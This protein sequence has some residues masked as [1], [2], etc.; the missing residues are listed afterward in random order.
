MSPAYAFV[1]ATGIGFVAVLR[2]L[3]APAIVSRS[4]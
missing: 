3:T 1:A 2:S 4:C